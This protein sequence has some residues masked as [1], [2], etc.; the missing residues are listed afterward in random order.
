MPRFVRHRFREVHLI[1][2][3]SGYAAV[4]IW[5]GWYGTSLGARLFGTVWA[6]TSSGSAIAILSAVASGMIAFTGVVFSMAFIALQF[7]STAYSP[8]IVAQLGRGKFLP[9]AIGVFTG[10]FMYALLAIR[11]VDMGETT[12]TTTTVLF[13]ALAWL[14][15]SVA[16][17]LLMLPALVRM[18]VNR[19]LAHLDEQARQA[20][21]R[22]YGPERETSVSAPGPRDESAVTAQPI[23]QVVWHTKRPKHLVGFDVRRLIAEATKVG[24]VVHIPYA[25]GAMIGTGDRLVLVRGAE[26]EIPEALLRRAL[27]LE[28]DRSTENDPAYGI[29]L[30]VDTAIRALSPA[31]ND[32]GTAVD[33]LD[34]MRLVL[35]DLGLRDLDIGHLRDERGAVRVVFDAPTWDQLVTAALAEIDQY[36]RDSVP[37]QRRLARLV[38][39]LVETLP[40][41]RHPALLSV[42]AP[43][44]P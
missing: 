12:G 23:R 15:A 16:V 22:V 41:E 6:A 33:V 2:I 11:T 39:R 17:L 31:I 36:G 24:G 7:G 8:R 10:T 29:Q 14:L 32:P 4:A 9:H 30:L 20:V 28:L 38:Q 34:R 42:V 40:P 37:V 44:A 35:R 18:T 25:I 13:T 27:W 3:A 19:V 1:G 26:A 43:K 5:L 21:A